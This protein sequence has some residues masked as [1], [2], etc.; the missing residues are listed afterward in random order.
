MEPTPHGVQIPVWVTMLCYTN[1]SPWARLLT[2]HWPTCNMTN[3]GVLE[4]MPALIGLKADCNGVVPD[5]NGV[6]QNGSRSSSVPSPAFVL[7]EMTN[8]SGGGGTK[9]TGNG[10][11]TI[12]MTR[13]GHRCSVVAVGSV[14]CPLVEGIP[15]RVKLLRGV[16]LHINDH[17]FGRYAK[18]CNAVVPD[19]YGVTQIGS[20][21]SSMTSLAL[22]L[23][24]YRPLGGT[25]PL[26]TPVGSRCRG[27]PGGPTVYPCRP[28]FS[29]SFYTVFVSREM[30]HG[31][32]IL[33]AQA[34][35]D[36]YA[37]KCLWISSHFFD[38]EAEYYT[39]L[40]VCY[41]YSSSHLIDSEP[42][43]PR[44]L[45]AKCEVGNQCQGSIRHVS[46][47]VC[48]LM[49]C[50]PWLARGLC[51]SSAVHKGSVVHQFACVLLR[52]C[53]HVCII[54][55]G[56][57]CNHCQLFCISLTILDGD[58][59]LSSGRAQQL[60]L[61]ADTSST[62]CP[63]QHVLPCPAVFMVVMAPLLI[64]AC[65]WHGCGGQGR[66][67]AVAGKFFNNQDPHRTTAEQ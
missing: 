32:S 22:V 25:L 48:T 58:T 1:E 35:E 56:I 19:C 50:L 15:R 66:G 10:A 29:Q 55:T 38:K 17:G 7:V 46:D 36:I 2:L 4:P 28:G 62:P 44:V 3:L 23:L 30:L 34:V 61:R 16:Q 40:A 57:V 20:G 59:L 9:L 52:V 31:Q 24:W 53:A 60:K 63:E 18:D 6:T 64:A 37:F 39:L 21:S 33:K 5:C 49:R 47:V 27:S 14:R 42:T 41:V 13:G 65:C 11:G 12:G 8:E 26:L 51:E 67:L 43:G 45:E 54:L